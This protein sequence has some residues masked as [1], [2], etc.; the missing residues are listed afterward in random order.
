MKN[1]KLIIE[2]DGTSYFG[3][4]KQ[5]IG[6]TIQQKVEDALKK[7]TREEIEVLGSSRTDS[8]VHARAYVANFKTHSNIPGKNFKAALNSKLPKDIVI[9]N[10]EEVEEEF[11]ARY[12]TKGK[13][14]CYTILN[15]E[16][17]PALER[18]Y[19]YHV[20]KKLD[21]EAMKKACTYFIGK[22]DFKAFQRP[23]GTV[24]TSTRT[25]S[26]LHIETDKD[27]IKIYVSAD[28]FLYNMVRLIV[29]TLLKVGRG[30]EKP[31]FIKE[32]IETGDRKKA[33][34]CVPA[35]GLCLEKVF[36]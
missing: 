27:K 9:M 8:G 34:I 16:E 28:G 35:S 6:N 30:K 5:P 18:N 25:I 15:R 31:E 23:G 4:Q 21:I 36:Y 1:I 17:P 10:S 19:V 2:Y 12:M 11:H 3:W 24:K 22:H 13:T 7:V 26:D 33:G 14:Y 20:K 29:G 32:V